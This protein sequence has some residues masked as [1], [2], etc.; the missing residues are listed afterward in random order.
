MYDIPIL[1]IIYKRRKKTDL[2][3]DEIRKLK[4]KKLYIAADGPKNLEDI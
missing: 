2:V 4:P 1:F 3:F